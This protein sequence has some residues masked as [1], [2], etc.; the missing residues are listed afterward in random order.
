MNKT[1]KAGKRRYYF[2]IQTTQKGDNY[3]VVTES[4]QGFEEGQFS[5]TRIFIYPEDFDKFSEALKETIDLAQKTINPD[6]N[7]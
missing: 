6:S 2:D 1:V 7:E 3:I 4:K 5:K